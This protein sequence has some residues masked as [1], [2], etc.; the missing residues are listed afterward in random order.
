MSHPEE[1]TGGRRRNTNEK[2]FHDVL[3][4]ILFSYLLSKYSDK[5]KAREM[6]VA[7]CSIHVRALVLVSC[8]VFSV[9]CHCTPVSCVSL[10]SCELCVT[11]LL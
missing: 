10:Y 7:C 11:V 4:I 9:V 2:T 3:I 6:L 8:V 5:D 1:K